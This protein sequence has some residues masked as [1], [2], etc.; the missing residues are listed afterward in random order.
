MALKHQELISTLT[1]E[2]KCSLLSGFD[3]W[4]T[5]PIGDKIPAAFLSDGP[6]GLRKQAKAADHLGLNP[7]IP[8]ACMPSSATVAN[9]WDPDLA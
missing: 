8:A 7:S 1:L 6:S 2:Q 4:Q 5:E 9:S 3:F